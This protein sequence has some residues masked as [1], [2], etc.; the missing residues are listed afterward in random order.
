MTNRLQSSLDE[1]KNATGVS[2]QW[3]PTIDA[4]E[5]LGD[6]GVLA[7]VHGGETYQL[8]RTKQNKLLLTKCQ[9]LVTTGLA[10]QNQ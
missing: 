6:A 9:A 3:M 2:F 8:T 5:L 10:Q 7:I 4:Q 1:V